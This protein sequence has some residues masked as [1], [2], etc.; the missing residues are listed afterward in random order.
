MTILWFIG[1]LA[2]V[3]ATL[4]A[5]ARARATPTEVSGRAAFVLVALAYSAL[6]VAAVWIW[7]GTTA[8]S[9]RA[10]RL[11]DGAAVHLTLDA[12]RAP[13]ATTIGHDRD[14]T[15]RIPGDGGLVATV[16]AGA[17]ASDGSAGA[18]SDGRAIVRGLDLAAIRA[19]EDPA[20]AAVI[21]G[22]APFESSFA[23][24][25]GAAVVALDCG[26]Q[27]AFVIRELRG[28]LAITPLV[29]HGHFVAEQLT[30]RTGDT[31]RIGGA[32]EIIPGLTTWDVIAPPAMAMLAVPADPT[33]CA[34]WPGRAVP[35]G[36]AIDAGAFT[37]T[38]LPLVPDPDAVV[39]R[40]LRAAF[41]IGTPSLLLLFAF[42]LAP[43][44]ERR[45][46]ALGGALRLCVLG[47]AF[48]AL[49]AWR[50]LWAYRIDMLRELAPLGT[51]LVDNQLAV[52]AIG[53]ALAGNAV[54]VFRPA[55]M[56][57]VRSGRVAIAAIAWAA[58]LVIGSVVVGELPAPTATHLGV[59]GLSLLVALAPVAVALAARLTARCGP[60]LA[61]L[62]IAGGALAGKAFA[63][64]AALGKLGLAYAFVLAAHAALR[65]A[66]VRETSLR[67]RCSGLAMI[68][69]AAGALAHYDMGVTL[70]IAG[71]GLALVM[72][73]AGHDA[74][75][76]ASQAARIGV[77]EREHARLLVVH[78]AAA[79]LVAIGVATA[80]LL[81]SD[82]EL[83]AN[84]TLVAIHAPL[85]IAALFAAAA[86][87]ARSHRRGWLPWA[88]AAV[89]AVAVWCGRDAIVERATG[90]DNVGARRIAAVVEP[91][92]A[93]LRDE[94]AFVANA[95]A[96]REAAS[97][98]VASW[99]GQGYFGA[100]IRDPGVAR[101]IDND[102]LP[103]LVARETGVGGLTQ[104][105]ALLLIVAIGCGAIASVRARHA[106]RE[107][108]ARWLIT[109]V[110]GLLAVYQPLAALGVLP[111]TGISWPGLGIDSPTDLWLFVLG[112]VW[113]LDCGSDIVDDERIRRSARLRRARAIVLGA[114]GVAVSAGVIIVAR[115]GGSALGRA[116]TEDARID[117]ALHYASSIACPWSE[118]EGPEV[119]AVIGG[120]PAD[121]GTA[122]YDRELRG[123][124]VAERPRLVEALAN[125][126]D[127]GHW[128]LARDGEGCVATLRAGVPTIRLRVDASHA[129]CSVTLSQSLIAALRTAARNPHAPR[130]R[131]VGEAMGAAANDVGELVSGA[132]IVRLRPGAPAHELATVTAGMTPAGSLAIGHA[133]LEIRAETVVLH[134][135]AQLF[136][137]DAGQWRRMVHGPEVLLDRVT[138]IAAGDAVVLFRPRRDWPGAPPVV[139]TLLADDTSAVGDR[140][141]R[142][143]PYGAALPELGWV[144]PFDVDHSLGL[145]GWIHA[146]QLRNNAA[147]RTG[148]VSC[149]TLSPPAIPRDR[150]CSVSPLDGVTECRVTLQPELAAALHAIADQ[151]IAQ[152]KAHLGRDLVP[153]RVSYVALR[154]DTGELLAQS[155][156]VPGRGP[157]AYAPANATAEAALIALREARGESDAERVEWNLPIAVGSTLKPIVARAAE[158]AFPAQLAQLALTASG[159]GGGCRARH[160]VSIDPLLGHCPPA[161][162]AGSPT[163]ADVHEFLAHSPNWY[164]AALGLL[165]LGLPDGNF[166]VKGEAVAFAEIIASDLAAWPASSPLQIADAQGPIITGRSVILDGLRRT[167]LWSHVEGLLGRPLC[168]LGDRAHCEA[169]AERA[170]VC[171]ARALPLANPSRD[172]RY[173]VSLGPDQLDLYADDRAAQAKVPIV[174]YFQLLRGS[175]V[176]AIGS[177]AQLTDAFGRVVYGAPVAAS[178]FPAPAAGV[179]PAWSCAKLA[180]PATTVLGADGGL[181]AVVQP[182]GTAHGALDKLLAD[183]SIVIYGAKTGTVDSLSDIARHDP[184]CR[185][186]NEHHP[187]TQL[188][189]GKA[190]PDD[191]LFVIAFGVV[192]AHGTIP[193]TLGL[194]LQ[195]AGKGTAAHVTPELIHAIAAYFTGTR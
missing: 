110:A 5:A 17:G 95:S 162:L 126:R 46:S 184:A 137:S 144:N 190:P 118:H 191:S 45:T 178:W 53:A 169:A 55:P 52:I 23:L 106:S 6:V 97:P 74:A 42:A 7:G 167:P 101:S 105:I 111:L 19:G 147:R 85:A 60:G 141:R 81:A 181:C 176:H 71:I 145:D 164:Q 80:A 75:Y 131:V 65:I 66:L 127:A 93:L 150:V 26:A 114:L 158:Q 186:W 49:C 189:C 154:G 125:C 187:L 43:R 163:T 193:I 130:I 109:A 77:L 90:G 134:G 27:R 44:R 113:C 30:A 79:I 21:R 15:I 68:T 171:S 188:V 168:T 22:C 1:L 40:G 3:I 36:C 34:A 78:G 152:P 155:T 32:S 10:A 16:T 88:C 82:R 83:I 165:G 94:R 91:G 48:T 50:L 29:W 180:K 174:E 25:P 13:A 120:T 175:G 115:A 69:F 166:E 9:G 161:S 183:P 99:D 70:A 116:A 192:T 2:L 139:D 33:D 149:G 195:R 112:A 108:R 172:L 102:Y 135:A 56:S 142:A 20:A 132:R 51:R 62:A 28:S 121:D 185:A 47:T 18:R 37:V 151:I 140:T 4:V 72:L 104:T 194:Q 117:A 98:D 128:R 38:A 100:R 148:D 179:V 107:H 122:R 87:V 123:Q 54:L 103:V 159:H 133:S 119:P 136:V 84:G 86:V 129:T 61:L 156:V 63:P 76:D 92:Y 143:Y 124:F 153:V 96:W 8:A 39:D 11:R 146:A 173:L 12:V 160:G 157:L 57:S 64:R 170:D 67:D 182:T 35:G 138:L 177:L 89:A 24:A 59:L 41:A 73:V 31:L 58:W 14:A